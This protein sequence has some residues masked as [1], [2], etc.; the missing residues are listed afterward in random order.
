[1]LAAALGGVRVGATATGVGAVAGI[2]F[3]EESPAVDVLRSGRALPLIL[4]LSVCGGI[5]YLIDVLSRLRREAEAIAAEQGRL[6]EQL[7]EANRAKDQFLA[8]VSHELRTPLT[9][10]V[11]WADLLKSGGLSEE[12]AAKALDTI[13]RNARIRTHGR[14]GA[15]FSLYST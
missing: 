8:T 5:V 1:M 6:A 3:L 4:Y 11:G 9:A 7:A 12:K 14:A 10:I 2:L 13:E 15:Q